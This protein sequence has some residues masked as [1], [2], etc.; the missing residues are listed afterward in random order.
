MTT[1]ASPTSGVQLIEVAPELA[2]QRIDNFLRTQLKGVPKTLIYRILRK[3]EVRVNKGRIKPEYKLQA[4]DVVRVPP[5][6]LAE[7]D[8]PEPLAQGLLERLEA[9]IVYEDKALIVLNKP[10]GIAV[11]GG[12]GLNYGVIE[13]FRQL[14]PDAKDLELVH[15]LDRDTSGL[16]MIAKKRSMLRH[17]HEALR[18]DGVD[19]RYMALVRG[20]WATAKKQVNAPLQKSNLRSGERM[21]EVDGEGKEALTLFRVLRRFGDFATLVEAKPVTGRTHQIRV[22]AKHAGHSIAG[23]SKYGDDEF[24]REIRELGGKRLF[25]HAYELH[26]PLPDGGVLKL[27][28]PVDEVWARTLERLSA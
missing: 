4:G 22:H 7:R 11:H 3:G 21:V 13:A 12:S 25:L 26:V 5:L 28:A 19:K 2:G 1:P 10:A 8:E 24:T 9:A 6:R 14:R 27:E 18:G 15:R 20:H 16:L 23:D 17:L